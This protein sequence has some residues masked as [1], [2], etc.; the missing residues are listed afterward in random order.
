MWLNIILNTLGY[1]ILVIVTLI[2]LLFLGMISDTGLKRYTHMPWYATRGIHR[3][4]LE[5]NG[6][7]VP[8]FSRRV[9]IAVVVIVASS[10]LIAYKDTTGD[11]PF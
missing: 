6:E 2:L 7:P 11:W 10:F 1:S 9:V 5:S 8:T 3:I 4:F